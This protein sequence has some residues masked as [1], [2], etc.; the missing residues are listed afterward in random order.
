MD[1]LPG[2]LSNR[3]GPE[4]ED[5]RDSFELDLIPRRA[6]PKVT[7]GEA[8]HIGM[9]AALTFQELPA[10]VSGLPSFLLSCP[11]SSQWFWR[12]RN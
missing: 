5:P 3:G 7:R 6:Q 9:K 4:L 2:Q 12:L 8:Q 11:L 10:L 1:L